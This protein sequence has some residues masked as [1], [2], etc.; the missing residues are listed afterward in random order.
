MRGPDRVRD[1]LAICAA[2][3]APQPFGRV[4]PRRVL[5]L[6]PALAL[7]AEPA[8]YRVD[9]PLMRDESPR[10]G[11]ID[12]GRH[13]G[14]R[15]GAQEQQLGDA[16]SQ[17][18]VDKGRAGR[19]RRIQAIGDQRVDLAEPAQHRRHQQPGKGAVAHRQL[20]HRRIV[21]D[22]VVE[23]PLAAQDG[24]DQVEGYLAGSRLGGHQ[25]TSRAN[26]VAW[27]PDRDSGANTP[28]QSS[29]RKKWGSKRRASCI[30]ALPCGLE[31]AKLGCLYC[32]HDRRSQRQNRSADHGARREAENAGCPGAAAARDRRA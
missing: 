8:Q 32:R 9:Q 13:G 24:A 1:L 10:M 15:R 12:A 6:D 23:R 22:G 16:E 17:D 26:G 31:A 27:N 4:E 11:E 14:V 25:G 18:V 28:R 19:Q 5:A 29:F 7:D 3:G 30:P 2:P 21:F 20:G